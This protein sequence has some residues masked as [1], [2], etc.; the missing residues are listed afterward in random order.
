MVQSG[1]TDLGGIS[2]DG[3]SVS[4]EFDWPSE[5]DLA[6]K[7]RTFGYHLQERLPI[8][9]ES[10]AERQPAADRLRQ[11]LVGDTVTYIVN[12]QRQHQQRLRGDL[13]FLRF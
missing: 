3:D 5:E 10:L 8:Y 13:L 11:E 1:A 4:P 6:A 2:L 7:A 12:R 9:Q